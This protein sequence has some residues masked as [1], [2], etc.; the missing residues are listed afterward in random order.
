MNSNKASTNQPP[1][2]TDSS[3]VENISIHVFDENR[4][5]DKIFKCDKQM[6]IKYMKYFEKYLTEASSV[7]DIDI[8]VHCDIKIFE[9]LIKYLHQKEKLAKTAAANGDANN[10]FAA[11][12]IPYK[13]RTSEE[14]QLEKL[15]DL[16]DA[17]NIQI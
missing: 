3:G 10:I 8:S 7:D 13:K 1:A 12:H 5:S 9:W 15:Q 6:L 16:E 2:P 4:K 11:K 14:R 17:K